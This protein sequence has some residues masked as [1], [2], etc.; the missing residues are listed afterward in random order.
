MVLLQKQMQQ[1]AEAQKLERKTLVKQLVS[2]KDGTAATHSAASIP[3]FSPFD[4]SAELW[5]DYHTR[6][7]TF[8]GAHTIPEDRFAQVFLTNQTTA[9]Y[10]LLATLAEQQTPPKNV[11]TLTMEDIVGFMED[12][13]DPKLFTVRE[14]F[15][16]WSDMRRKPGE[17]LHD[18]AAQIRQDAATCDFT[19]IKDLQ[20]EAL[21]TH[22]ICSVG[23]EAVL[24]ALF[25]LSDDKLTFQRAVK[26]AAE[27]EDAA[28][29]AKETVHGAKATA[30]TPVFKVSQSEK[31]S[32]GQK[33]YRSPAHANPQGT[34]IRCGNTD[35]TPKHC[36]YLDA[37]CHFCWKKGHLEAVCLQRKRDSGQSSTLLT[38]R[39]PRELSSTSRMSLVRAP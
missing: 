33:Q 24:K 15:K 9:N 34:C 7:N 23:N 27:T 22:F 21:R 28:K 25:K 39:N 4:H 32:T 16:F 35:H 26:V 13:F 10:K 38:R 31:T 5:K 37:T 6:F 17:T 19:S 30:A 20:D 2:T 12:Q 1:L 29:V 14:C 18:L 11:N 8:A 3:S 36:R